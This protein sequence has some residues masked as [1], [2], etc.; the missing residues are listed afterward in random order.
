[1]A[2]RKKAGRGKVKAIRSTKRGGK[3]AAAGLVARVAVVVAAVSKPWR[4]SFR[5][6]RACSIR[7]GHALMPFSSPT[8]AARI[9]SLS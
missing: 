4:T 8:R 1:M 2:A 7:F 9:L 3:T 6:P 5:K